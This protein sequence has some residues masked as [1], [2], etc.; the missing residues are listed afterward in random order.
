V[1]RAQYDAMSDIQI[2]DNQWQLFCEGF[3]RQHHGWLVSLCQ[4]QTRELG[5]GDTPAQ[6]AVHLFPGTRPLEEVR[7]GHSNGRAE[8]MV[9]VGEGSDETSFL[10]EDAVALYTRRAGDAHQGL[11]VDSGNGTSTLIEF[12]TPAEPET[13]DGL[14]ESEISDPD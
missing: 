11:R 9:T 5:T 13:L 4:L 8:I 10:I 2:P 6:T 14:A 7:E 12:R 3:T 1:E